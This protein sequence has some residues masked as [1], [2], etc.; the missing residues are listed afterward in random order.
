MSSKMIQKVKLLPYDVEVISEPAKQEPQEVE[1][2][3]SAEKKSKKHN[4]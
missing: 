1:E 4:S 3:E 2:V